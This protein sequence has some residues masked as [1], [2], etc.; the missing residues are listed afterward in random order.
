[1]YKIS[2]IMKGF[3]ESSMKRWKT[4]L[5]LS[6]EEGTLTSRKINICS[7]IFQRDS[8]SPLLF[9]IALAPLSSLRNSSG[10]GFKTSYMVMNHLFYMNDLKTITKND[11][12]QQ[13]QLTIVKGFSDDIK[14]EFGMEKCA[15]AF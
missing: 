1:M 9:C 4:T 14:M 11:E 8:L 15:K 3:I 5:H 13:S 7:G 12:E 2:P 6:H 10:Y